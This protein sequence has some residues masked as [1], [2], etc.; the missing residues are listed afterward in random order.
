V[1]EVGREEG[2][3]RRRRRGGSGGREIVNNFSSSILFAILKMMNK[4]IREAF[5]FCVFTQGGR[6]GVA[7]QLE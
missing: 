7:R 5:S 2:E 1:G 6:V 3:R 4:T